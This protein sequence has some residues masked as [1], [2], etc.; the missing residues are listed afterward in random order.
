[1]CGFLRLKHESIS[2]GATPNNAL[3]D[4][5]VLNTAGEALGLARATIARQIDDLLRRIPQEADTLFNEV[6]QENAA[7]IAGRPE[8]TA[9]L[10]GSY[11]H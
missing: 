8:L 11:G 3:F 4:R 10:G 7:I 5:N 6:E 9:T 2:T 1:M